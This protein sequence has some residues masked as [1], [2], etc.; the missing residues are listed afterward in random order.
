[1]GSIRP[2]PDSDGVQRDVHRQPVEPGR[3]TRTLI[4]PADLLEE[5]EENILR[6]IFGQRRISN[7]APAGAEDAVLVVFV[8]DP[9]ARNVPAS[10][11]LDR[12]AFIGGGHRK[13]RCT[14][15]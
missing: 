1:M 9:E 15:T 2:L 6:H 13:W 7:H 12:L 8:E 10:T 4:I 14:A 3:E 11:R 5:A